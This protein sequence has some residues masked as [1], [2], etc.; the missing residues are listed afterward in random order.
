[1]NS[2]MQKLRPFLLFILLSI[3]K[4]SFS[5]QDPVIIEYIKT[6]R[7]IAIGEMKRT[8][9]PAAIKLAQGIHETE[10]GTSE[11][12]L[13]SNNHF[14]LKCK[15]EWTGMTVSHTDDAPNECFRKYD[16]PVDSYKDQSDYLKNTRWYAS[17]FN[18]DPTNYTAW[19]YGLKRAGYATNPKYPQILIKL[20]EDYQLQDYTL[21]ALGKLKPQEEVFVKTEP[22]KQETQLVEKKPAIVFAEKPVI[23]PDEPEIV[24]TAKK[25]AKKEEIV[26]QI[27][28][29][30]EQAKE[31]I[32]TEI[33]PLYP[34]GEFKINE[35]RVVYIKKG[36][37][38]LTIA[39]KYGLPLARIFEFND[40]KEL[41]ITGKDGLIY[42]M[43]KRK[44]GNNDQHIVKE[45][46]TLN[47]IAQTEAIRIES[48]LEYNLLKPGMKPAVGSILYLKTKAPAMPALVSGN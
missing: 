40:M 10:A 12:V 25:P 35:T 41:E 15:K 5:Q 14:G 2:P 20:I 45:G 33:N 30:K 22:V 42:I 48:I 13:K 44:T 1:M 21:I 27:V 18:L 4:N 36:T 39:E 17:L 26:Q 43:R 46:E 8:G 47:D 31:Q 38:Y 34:E 3:A 32:K 37:H 7:D 11:L 6:Y 29:P 24:L 28:L 16:N 23:M 9:V 19:A